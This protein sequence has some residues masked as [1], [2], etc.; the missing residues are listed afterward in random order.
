MEITIFTCRSPLSEAD[1]RAVIRYRRWSAGLFLL[2]LGV[3]YLL[4]HQQAGHAKTALA[5][6]T[7]TSF[8]AFCVAIARLVM[9][10]LD[11]FQRVLMTR[12]FLWATFITMGLVS[13]WSYWEEFAG[14]VHLPLLDVP[15]ALIVMTAVVKVVVF[16]QN[17]PGEE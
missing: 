2:F 17:S 8:F 15:V 10:R 14:G 12:S 6:V 11:E 4:E 7:G 13:V 5:L 9:S 3:N 16:R 1:R